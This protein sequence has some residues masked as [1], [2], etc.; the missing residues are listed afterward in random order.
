MQ[1]LAP[2]LS[3]AIAIVRE[4][5][6]LEETVDVKEFRSMMSDMKIDEHEATLVLDQ[7]NFD[8]GGLRCDELL[9]RL[10][11]MR[12]ALE[13]RKDN[14]DILQE[15]EKAPNHDQILVANA[16]YTSTENSF[17]PWKRTVSQMSMSSMMEPDMSSCRVQVAAGQDTAGPF[18]DRHRTYLVSISSQE[19][20]R[21]VRRYKDFEW[22]RQTL[23]HKYPFRIIPQIPPK[24][25][26][27][28]SSEQFLVSRRRG[29]E[30]F[31]FLIVNH[32]V[33][34]KDPLLVDFL[35]V[36]N[37]TEIRSRI[38]SA[39]QEESQATLPQTQTN[40]EQE[41]GVAQ[42]PNWV[43]YEDARN[44][45]TLIT[46]ALEKLRGTL[47]GLSG[48]Q[49]QTQLHLGTIAHCV[50]A[51]LDN[52]QHRE[53]EEKKFPKMI[54]SLIEPHTDLISQLGL[55]GLRLEV[56]LR[57]LRGCSE[58]VSRIKM[59]KFENLSKIS[60]QIVTA[61]ATAEK[62]RI[63]DGPVH[64]SELD[65]VFAKISTLQREL[66]YHSQRNAFADECLKQELGWVVK[67]SRSLMH[68]FTAIQ[69]SLQHHY[70][71]LADLSDLH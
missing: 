52:T 56:Y 69:N 48:S 15:G 6:A 22:L 61:Q 44:W 14:V 23:V 64:T 30:E 33:L 8:K 11:V 4:R 3:K 43:I 57:L 68:V 66:L 46:E 39:W 2:T 60:N 37:F 12:E 20:S 24:K 34:Q 27:L 18:Y 59:S 55:D 41:D 65:Q 29:L 63:R 49:L 40:G 7:V 54:E 47:S 42:E 32:P 31:L 1:N 36:D 58:A 25:L 10:E 45:T 26:S 21:L 71:T 17:D 35:S 70:Q 13:H 16:G 53:V 28:T 19:G 51:L 62:L 50:R 5:T 9:T 67:M 38:C